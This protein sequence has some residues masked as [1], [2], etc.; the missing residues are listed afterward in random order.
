MN[1]SEKL[2]ILRKQHNLSQEELAEKLGVSRQAISRWEAGQSL[3]DT[4]NIIQLT[5]LYRVS[6]DYLLN[7]EYDEEN[8]I[9]VV[10]KAEDRAA[11]KT[12]AH[13]VYIFSLSLNVIAML[14]GMIGYFISRHTATVFIC[15]AMSILSIACFEASIVKLADDEIKAFRKKY[16][17]KTVW[18]VTIIP[19]SVIAGWIIPILTSHPGIFGSEFS[20]GAVIFL[21]TPI[22]FSV[23]YFPLCLAIKAGI[24]RK[25]R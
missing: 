17:D 21:S 19:V 22:A 5:K 15:L 12:R 18:I 4:V 10:K 3:P 7:D 23:L 11:K 13:M 24:K 8:D 20:K 6:A 14:A 16:Y 25:C 1:I 9:P 2:L